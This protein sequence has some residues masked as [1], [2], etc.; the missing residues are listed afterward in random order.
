MLRFACSGSVLRA[1]PLLFGTSGDDLGL[2]TVFCS[3]V[4]FPPRAAA[5]LVD[6]A[7][8]FVFSPS[9]VDASEANRVYQSCCTPLTELLHTA[10]NEPS[11][12]ALRPNVSPPFAHFPP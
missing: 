1:A 10:P 2:S 5:V 4:V 12:L 9:T 8:I 6:R 11:A 7:L 3:S